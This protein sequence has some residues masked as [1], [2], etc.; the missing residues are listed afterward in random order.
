MNDYEIEY[1]SA[2]LYDYVFK[3]RNDVSF[4]LDMANQF[5]GPI[6]EA[7]CG[8][9]R[10]LLPLARAGFEI[11]GIDIN[12]SRLAICETKLAEESDKTRARASAVFGD[13]CNFSLNREFALL[14]TPFRS[15]QH[16]L[17]SKDQR[18]ALLNMKRHLQPNGNLILD[19]FN[20]SIPFLANSQY[21]EEFGDEPPIILPDGTQ[22]LQRDRVISRN[23]WSQIQEAQEVYYVRYPDGS[24][25][26]IVKSYSSRYTFPYEL[27]HL[28]TTVGFSIET[29]FGDYDKSA[30]G[31]KYPGELIV[32]ARKTE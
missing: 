9:G 21:L 26:R 14:I 7:G 6:L 24:E 19:I 23:Y 29:M 2:Y 30:F 5:G 17:T 4:Y 27:E 3:S 18:T 1:L 20:P 22:I 8:T 15:F 28:L 31:D 11:V 10:I 25:E 16:L 13:M 32:I 12:T